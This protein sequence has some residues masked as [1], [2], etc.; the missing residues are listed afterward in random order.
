MYFPYCWLLYSSQHK[1]FKS[2]HGFTEII[3]NLI[4][5]FRRTLLSCLHFILYWSRLPASIIEE[6]LFH[7]WQWIL[8]FLHLHHNAFDDG[9]SL[10]CKNASYLS[11]T[12]VKEK[13][14]SFSLLF[15][16]LSSGSNHCLHY[17]APKF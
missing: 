7:H 16:N 10:K 2:S 13:S 4:K 6:L 11:C 8:S 1:P 5:H 9:S 14:T 3:S 15:G 17:H 12:V